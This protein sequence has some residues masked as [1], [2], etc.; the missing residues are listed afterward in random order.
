MTFVTRKIA[1]HKLFFVDILYYMILKVVGEALEFFISKLV[2]R[3]A[4]QL[5]GF[6]GCGDGCGAVR[7]ELSTSAE[8]GDRGDQQ[9]SAETEH[10]EGQ[11]CLKF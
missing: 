11:V 9:G 6:R 3:L 1:S 7:G 2:I 10:G 5:L 8:G 4:L